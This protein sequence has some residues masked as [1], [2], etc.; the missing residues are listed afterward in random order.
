MNI[1]LTITGGTAA[2]IQQAVQELSGSYAVNAKGELK[3]TARAK[4]HPVNGSLAASKAE[5]APEMPT[6]E[7][8]TEHP[9]TEPDSEKSYAIEDIRAAANQKAESGKRAEVKALITS[10]D[11]AKNI[12]ALDKKHYGAFMEKLNTL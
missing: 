3:E 8:V 10:F 5:K 11:G 1:T 12:N 2:E 4:A 6:A 9:V 7:P